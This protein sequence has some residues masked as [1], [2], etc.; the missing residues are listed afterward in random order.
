MEKLR[1]EAK[2]FAGAAPVAINAGRVYAPC[3]R[4]L[5][6]AFLGALLFTGC[7]DPNPVDAE[8]RKFF[9]S[10]WT[11]PDQAADR[12]LM[13]VGGRQEVSGVR[14]PVGDQGSPTRAQ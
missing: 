13:E 6:A 2:P 1:E 8:D 10:G 5:V 9:Y 7:A 12:R 14:Q 4:Y 3:M 11:H